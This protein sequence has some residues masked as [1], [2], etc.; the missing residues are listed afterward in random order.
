MNEI[1]GWISHLPFDY[2]KLKPSESPSIETPGWFL[3][4]FASSLQFRL[5]L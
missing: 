4:V 2:L 5:G 1:M 3:S